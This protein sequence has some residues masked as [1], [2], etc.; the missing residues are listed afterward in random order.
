MVDNDEILD[1]LREIRD[2]QKRHQE[3]WRRAVEQAQLDHLQQ[4]AKTKRKIWL[5]MGLLVLTFIVSNLLPAFTQQD[6]YPPDLPEMALYYQPIA[7]PDFDGSYTLDSE[8]SFPVL[9]ARLSEDPQDQR[10]R[11][12][13]LMSEQQFQN[14]RIKHGVITCGAM[15]VQEFR[16]VSGEII[17][18][19]LEGRAIWHEHI[20]DP[21]DAMVIG[22]RLALTG[23]TLEFS[24]DNASAVGP[25]IVLTKD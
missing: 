9:H 5:V 19:Q 3:E 2:E 1:L 22:I 24:Q 4:V 11:S 7:T 21:G 8:K 13:L 20:H 10:A 14:F 23:D 25:T 17:D 12:I 16:L 15:L 18:N 6:D